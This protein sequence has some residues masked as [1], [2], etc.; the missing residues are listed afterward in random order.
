MVL[1][2][3]EL[4]VS[5]GVNN[6]TGK[7]STQQAIELLNSAWEGG[8]REL[9]TAAAYGESEQ[10][11]GSFQEQT[12]CHFR[13][14]TKLPVDVE[15]EKLMDAFLAS[16]KRLKTD[17]IELLYLH[18]FSQCKNS[19]IM[20]FLDELKKQG[21]I[22]HIGISIYIPDE[23]RYIIEKLPIVDTI[24]FP[25]NIFDN[26]RWL[27]DGLLTKAAERNLY[28][29]SVFLQGLFFMN[30]NAPFAQE[31]G[32]GVFLTELQKIAYDNEMSVAELAYGYV[33]QQT[34]IDQI[35]VGC[36]DTKHLWSNL[37]LENS[38]KQI[39]E[40]VISRLEE[41]SKGIPEI[42]IDPRKWKRI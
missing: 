10:V 39:P 13:I 22:N 23:M 20:R 2:T 35:I 19:A 1:G 7:P 12:G 16:C 15:N 42:A 40:H 41:L 6:R 26:H 4:G 37:A 31:I 14:D 18:S 24:Q 33:K 25:Y 9:D 5:Y 3:V 32:A 34:M 28:V 17:T 38:P 21:R 30:P 27:D 8:I 36:K 11:I 29:R